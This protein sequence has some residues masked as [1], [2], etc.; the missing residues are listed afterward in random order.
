MHGVGDRVPH[1]GLMQA[2]TQVVHIIHYTFS[3]SDISY[4]FLRFASL[5]SVFSSPI[6][7]RVFSA[8]SWCILSAI[9]SWNERYFFLL[10]LFI[11]SFT[12]SFIHSC[13]R[14]NA[15]NWNAFFKTVHTIGAFDFRL[16][17]FFRYFFIL[18]QKCRTKM[19]N[20][21]EKCRENHNTMVTIVICIIRT[22]VLRNERLF[23]G[24]SDSLNRALRPFP[25]EIRHMHTQRV[26]AHS[27]W[28]CR[29]CCHCHCRCRRRHRPH[30]RCLFFV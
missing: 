27:V 24:S 4:E 10:F 1:L 16:C 13:A 7:L 11:H 6:V 3:V 18:F 5:R 23:S 29:N 15:K 17:I 2:H 28:S 8:T 26:N 21:D 25:F 14:I 20:S 22:C 30:H 9:A 19:K 12:R